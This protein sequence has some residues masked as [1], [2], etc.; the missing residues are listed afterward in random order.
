MVSDYIDTFYNRTCRHSH[1]GGVGDLH[2]GSPQS[3][4]RG[5]HGHRQNLTGF[6]FF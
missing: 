1:L 4:E 3:K 6:V 2:T 5:P